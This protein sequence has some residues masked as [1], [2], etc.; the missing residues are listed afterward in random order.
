MTT[1]RDIKNRLYEQVARIGKAAASP[2]RLELLE[3]LCQGEKT[4]ETLAQQADIDLK[5]ASAHLKELKAA[6]LVAARKDGKYVYHR[7]ADDAVAAFWVNLRSLAEVRLAELQTV[8]R[9]FL[10]D[11]EHL[12][13]VDRRAILGKAR[14]GEIIVIDVRPEQE[15]EGGHLPYAR[16]IP[17]AELKKR[18]ADLPRRKE[19][20]AYCRGPF[21]MMAK[22]AV[23][24]LRQKGF[25][26]VRLEDGVA[27]W[28]AAGLPV[29]TGAATA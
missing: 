1:P 20:V 25:K 9:E 5:S 7:L 15:Y 18:L 12:A 19:I 3:L 22:D 14:Q 23:A 11:P 17:L 10:A 8:V 29:E 21:C 27:E 2:K 28:R 24:L 26:A 6:R 13:P 16:S 4:V